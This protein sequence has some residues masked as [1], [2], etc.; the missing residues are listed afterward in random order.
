MASGFDVDAAYEAAYAAEDLVNELCPPFEDPGSSSI[1]L[2][3]DRL[4][5]RL[6]AELQVPA[7]APVALSREHD[8]RPAIL[9]RCVKIMALTMLRWSWGH[10]R[11]SSRAWAIRSTGVRAASAVSRTFWARRVASSFRAWSDLSGHSK[12]LLLD[13]SR[14]EVRF[15]CEAARRGKGR[16]LGWALAC[17][18]SGTGAHH[19]LLGACRG[20]WLTRACA[21]HFLS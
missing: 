10:L 18:C 6:P 2:T 5:S 21:W 4:L 12:A 13:E 11:A 3:A 8:L 19:L 17:V 1:L 20:R 14:Q 9:R 15:A 7:S 16:G